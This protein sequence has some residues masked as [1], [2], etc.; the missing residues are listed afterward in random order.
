[1]QAI[2]SARARY[3]RRAGKSGV[4]GAAEPAPKNT[5]RP[6]SSKRR[7][8]YWRR[9]RCRYRMLCAWLHT[10]LWVLAPVRS[11]TPSYG[12][13][14]A[15]SPMGTSSHFQHMTTNVGCSCKTNQHTSAENEKHVLSVGCAC[16]ALCGANTVF[17]VGRRW[18]PPCECRVPPL[19][20]CGERS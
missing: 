14:F 20:S 7:A 15:S 3:A 19:H 8:Q 5:A 12:Q 1:M 11:H 17:A 13:K 16:C 9:R 6:P 10:C 18:D 2:T 4:G